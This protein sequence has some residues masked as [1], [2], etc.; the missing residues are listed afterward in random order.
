MKHEEQETIGVSLFKANYHGKAELL[1]SYFKFFLEFLPWHN[2]FL[3]VSA[4][5]ACRFD[6]QPG[7]VARNCDWDLIP[8][9]NTLCALGWP[10]KEKSFFLYFSICLYSTFSFYL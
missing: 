3:G 5:L 8:G 1:N 9:P 10:K 4:A 2:G 7:G 6:P